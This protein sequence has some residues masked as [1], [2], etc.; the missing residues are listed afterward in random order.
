MKTVPDGYWTFERCRDEAL[1]YSSRRDF[2]AAGFAYKKA[3]VKGWRDEI[4]AHMVR[5][6]SVSHRFVYVISDP[7]AKS[8]YVGLTCDP[9]RR[10]KNHAI[11]GPAQSLIK[12][13]AKLEVISKLLA[14]SDAAELEIETIKKFRSL[15][16]NVLNTMKG[17]GLGGKAVWTI[18]SCREEA[19]KF[20]TRGDFAT[21]ATRAYNAAWEKGWLDEICAHMPKRKPRRM[22][23][24]TLEKVQSEASKYNRRVDFV[25]GSSGAYQCAWKRG[26]LDSVCQHM[27]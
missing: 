5:L 25:R 20:D 26:W 4:C 3:S 14:S 16:F 15:G 19:S 13:G 21:H 12:N 7:I 24:W 17:G 10:A 11:K 9:K 23:K 1:K 27:N 22:M 2:R 18:E 8:V 6:G